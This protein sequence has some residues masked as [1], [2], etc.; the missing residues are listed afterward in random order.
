MCDD[1]LIRA[2]IR[3]CYVLRTV[4]IGGRLNIIGCGWGRDRVAAQSMTS[5]HILEPIYALILLHS[6]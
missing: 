2:V 3:S 1:K 5:R 4:R 6:A